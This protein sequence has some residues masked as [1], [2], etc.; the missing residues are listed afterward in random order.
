MTV[1]SWTRK[2]MAKLWFWWS[3]TTIVVTGCQVTTGNTEY[4]SFLLPRP[5]RI[6]TDH[7][8]E[9]TEKSSRTIPTHLTMRDSNATEGFR[10]PKHLRGR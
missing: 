3:V 2:V 5:A 8:L 1:A 10:F 9:E 4:Q 6:S 7:T